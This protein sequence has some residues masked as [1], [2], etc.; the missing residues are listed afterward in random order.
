MEK[1]AQELL[2]SPAA[3]ILDEEI[4]R[5][6]QLLEELDG[7]LKAVEAQVSRKAAIEKERPRLTKELDEMGEMC[8]RDRQCAGKY[9][10]G[11]DMW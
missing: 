8:I 6:S 9:E 1:K 10:N 7:Q 2:E 3:E 4:R 11:K 5:Q